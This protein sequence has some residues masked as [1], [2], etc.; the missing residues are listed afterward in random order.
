MLSSDFLT[1]FLYP[2]HF[3]QNKKQTLRSAFISVVILRGSVLRI[4]AGK[5]ESLDCGDFRHILI[6]N[7][8]IEELRV[9]DDAVLV[10]G[11]GQGKY[12]VLERKAD[13]ELSDGLIITR[14][15]LRKPFVAEDGAAAKRAP[16]FNEDAVR[17]APLHVLFLEVAGMIL[18][19]IDHRLDFSRRAERF[20]VLHVKVGNTD[21]ADL[22]RLISLLKG[23][24]GR[25]VDLFPFGRDLL[26]AGPVNEVQVEIIGPEIFK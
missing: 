20:C 21:S 18:K 19:L 25:G 15:D 26:D 13:A 23:S 2:P 22:A 17:L 24:P 3:A 10:D 14:R 9:I 11:L 7:L 5:S 6:G 4:P 12:A 1:F 8:E 16:R